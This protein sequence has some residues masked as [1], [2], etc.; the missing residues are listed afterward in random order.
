[1]DYSKA[2]DKLFTR[3]MQCWD[4]AARNYSALGDVATRTLSL[5]ESAV[6]LQF[7]PER[8]RSSAASI[9]K[10]SLA[11]RKCFLCTEN[12]P[13]KQRPCCGVIAT[14]FKSILIPSSSVT[15]R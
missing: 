4:V 12:Q 5:G 2:I 9:D 13:V 8:R 14:R 6:V 1:M 15:S 3:Q 10:K 11:H 7:N